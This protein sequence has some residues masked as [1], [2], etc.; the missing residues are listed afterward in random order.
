MCFLNPERAL[1]ELLDNQ[2]VEP[3]QLIYSI[4]RNQGG[5]NA[6]ISFPVTANLAHSNM[7][8]VAFP[9]TSLCSVAQ[10]RGMAHSNT[11]QTVGQRYSSCACLAETIPPHRQNEV[12]VGLKEP[13]TTRNHCHPRHVKRGDRSVACDANG[14]AAKRRFSVVTGSFS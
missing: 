10:Y 6:F 9:G 5:L 11:I 12:R 7:H 13:V 14:G 8:S 4:L 1:F 3:H 2:R